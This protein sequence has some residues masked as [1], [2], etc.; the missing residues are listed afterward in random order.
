MSTQ[1]EGKIASD[2]Q[3]KAKEAENLRES[4]PKLPKNSGKIAED[5][6][7]KWEQMKEKQATQQTQATQLN[8]ERRIAM[9]V[10]MQLFELFASF[11]EGIL[12]GKT[13]RFICDTTRDETGTRVFGIYSHSGEIVTLFIK[14]TGWRKVVAIER[15]LTAEEREYAVTAILAH[16][17]KEG[18]KM[19][20]IS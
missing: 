4:I 13:I 6:M 20:I 1:V 12:K 19:K 15:K 11:D 9:D 8:Q 5:I 10:K 17:K 14:E 7:S 3:Q 2:I 18:R 16:E